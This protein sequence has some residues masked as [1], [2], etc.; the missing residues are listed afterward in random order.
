MCK[1]LSICLV[2]Q[3]FYLNHF[4]RFFLFQYK[5]GSEIALSTISATIWRQIASASPF[6]THFRTTSLYSL[7]IEYI[8][9]VF[10]LTY[11][12]DCNLILA[13]CKHFRTWNSNSFLSADTTDAD[14]LPK[15]VVIKKTDA[16]SFLVKTKFGSQGKII[17]IQTNLNFEDI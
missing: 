16:R 10:R 17:I 2:V 5:G 3:T 1:C 11:P 13:F 4:K 15:S 9:A 7:H 12:F 6:S 14:Y 8:F